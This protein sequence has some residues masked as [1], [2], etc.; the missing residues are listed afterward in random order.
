MLEQF[1]VYRVNR[2]RMEEASSPW[3]TADSIHVL[4]GDSFDWPTL[5]IA[6]LDS[7][8]R[9]IAVGLTEVFDLFH[10]DNNSGYQMNFCSLEK[11]CYSNSFHIDS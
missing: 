5:G 11:W 2:F 1:A 3:A 6:Y 9:N 7:I 10:S 8:C 4:F